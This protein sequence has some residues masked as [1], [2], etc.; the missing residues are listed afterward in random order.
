MKFSPGASTGARSAALHI[1]SNSV[2]DSPFGLNLAGNGAPVP[3]SAPNLQ[4]TS[5][6]GSS[7]TDNITN[8]T[9]PVFDVTA[10]DGATPHAASGY[11]IAVN[12]TLGTVTVAATL[13]GAAASPASPHA[14][15]HWPT[16]C[17]PSTT[18]T[19]KV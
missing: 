19:I 5:D 11:V 2:S 15:G 1:T 16:G 13:G 3:P 7:Q 12:R 4:D 9:A 18:S 8:S 10:T 6:S 17:C 14:I